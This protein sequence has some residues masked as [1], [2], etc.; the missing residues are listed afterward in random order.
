MYVKKALVTSILLAAAPLSQQVLAQST[1]VS[2]MPAGPAPT[3]LAQAGS[4]DC[5]HGFLTRFADAYREDAQPA[6]SNSPAPA[7]RAMDAPFDSPPFPNSEWQLGGVPAPIGVPD[8]K[9]H[10]SAGKSPGLHQG[11]PMDAAQSHRGLRLGDT[12]SQWEYVELYEFS[13]SPTTHAQIA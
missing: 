12:G 4:S 6:S 8:T 7:R 13:A 11:R 5:S 3:A 2:A 1:N 10:V 9:L